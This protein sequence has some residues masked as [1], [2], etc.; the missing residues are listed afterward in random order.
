MARVI[1]VVLESSIPRLRLIGSHRSGLDDRS[2]DLS[3]Q[4]IA[5]ASKPSRARFINLS[6]ESVGV[7]MYRC[8]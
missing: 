2:E 7:M 5:N 3:P 6:Y 8:S 4:L 1:S